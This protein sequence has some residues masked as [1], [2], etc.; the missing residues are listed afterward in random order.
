M[1]RHR[2]DTRTASAAL[3]VSA[4]IVGTLITAA[5]GAYTG[6]VIATA[7][8]LFLPAPVAVMCAGYALI[9]YGFTKETP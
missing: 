2:R 3:R 1:T 5:G 7:E 8:W 9:V 6:F 4:I